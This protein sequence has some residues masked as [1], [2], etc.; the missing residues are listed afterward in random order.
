MAWR[1]G[2]DMIGAT[3]FAAEADA[4]A[5]AASGG[6]I[7]G[8][9]TG[10][11]TGGTG[12]A[13]VAGAD[14]CGVATGA[15][16][17][18]S[19]PSDASMSATNSPRTG[20]AGGAAARQRCGLAR[21]QARDFR[22]GR[23]YDRC[24]NRRCSRLGHG[25][26]QEAIAQ[27][28]FEIGNELV[29]NT[30]VPDRARGSGEHRFRLRLR[31]RLRRTTGISSTATRLSGHRRF[32]SVSF[33]GDSTGA[34]STGVVI[35]GDFE[36]RNI[37]GG[38]FFDHG[39]GCGRASC[40]AAACVAASTSAR[41]SAILASIAGQSLQ[42]GQGR[43]G[44]LG[45]AVGEIEANLFDGLVGL[46]GVGRSDRATAV[47]H[48]SASA[49]ATSTSAASS[50]GA[51]V[52]TVRESSHSEERSISA[53]AAAGSSEAVEDSSTTAN[54]G[55][56]DWMGSRVRSLGQGE[57]ACDRR[58]GFFLGCR[59]F[60]GDFFRRSFVDGKFGYVRCPV[61]EPWLNLCEPH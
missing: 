4:A 16:F 8:A 28:S 13:C 19:S 1:S 18:K 31:P 53:E 29:Q 15:A 7:F 51:S 35:D 30:R 20:A 49:L 45:H 57:A 32:S 10:A 21:P 55:S 46:A 33:S 52:S 27:R 59:V 2:R 47:R 5:L 3:W 25:A 39:L 17:R 41:S 9:A 36:R 48:F 37:V 11:G 44:L 26:G 42:L 24:C 61:L 38:Q 56:A 6:I 58:G 34:S 60:N 22:W 43:H 54:S 50:A 14:G 23:W 12:L 40:S